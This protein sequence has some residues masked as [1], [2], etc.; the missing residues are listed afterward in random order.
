VA[1]APRAGAPEAALASF[2]REVQ[3][4]DAVAALRPPRCSLIHGAAGV[5][6]ALTRLARLTGDSVALACAER[7]LAAAEAAQHAPGAFDHGDDEPPAAATDADVSPFHAASG[8]AAMRA[9]LSYA[10]GDRRRQQA[11]LDDFRRVTQAPCAN[12][13]LTLGRSAVLLFAALLLADAEPGWPAA[14]RLERHGDELSLGIWRDLATKGMGYLGIAHGWAG[15]AYA[16]M[17]WAR[18]RGV[19]PPPAVPDVLAMLAAAAM[20]FEDSEWWPL[21]AADGPG[22]D[23]FWPGWCHGTA[24]YVFLWNLAHALYGDDDYAVRAE[25]AARTLGQPAQ[26]DNLCC[27][28]AGQAYAALNQHRSTGEARWH[29]LAISIANQDAPSQWSLG[30]TPRPLSLYRGKLG[31]ALLA[32]ELE[33]PELAAMPLFEFERHV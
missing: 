20:P 9:F 10:T 27:G 12:V 13:D 1:S 24:G 32:V 21:T 29:S 5:C 4:T 15:V 2:R 30:D 6:F 8:L 11:A 18:V 16:S 26:V 33:R 3:T 17:M 25:H 22:G 23:Q 7:W 19:P 28:S 14:E 31:L